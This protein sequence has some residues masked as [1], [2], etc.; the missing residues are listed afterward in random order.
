MVSLMYIIDNK[1]MQLLAPAFPQNKGVVLKHHAH[2][3]MG[4][5]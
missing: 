5:L 3:E 4:A 2:T 1:T